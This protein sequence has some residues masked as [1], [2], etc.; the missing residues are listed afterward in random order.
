MLWPENKTFTKK[1]SGCFC[2]SGKVIAI[3]I[4]G[5]GLTSGSNYYGMAYGYSAGSI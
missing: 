1:C 2:I 3:Q 4:H 5:V